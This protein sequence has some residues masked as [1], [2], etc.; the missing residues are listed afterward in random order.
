MKKVIAI[1]IMFLMLIGTAS[2]DRMGFAL[3]NPNTPVWVRTDPHKNATICGFL[4][5]GDSVTLD[6]K[7]HGEWLHVVDGCFDGNAWVHSGYIV[8]IKVTVETHKAK[9]TAKV[10]T[11]NRVGGKITGTLRKGQELTVYAFSEEC[12]YTSRGYVKSKFLELA[13]LMED[14]QDGE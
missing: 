1:I 13:E 7:R 2:A 4:D 14:D 9:T 3:C 6:G 12:C 5:C 11:R 10:R 8:G